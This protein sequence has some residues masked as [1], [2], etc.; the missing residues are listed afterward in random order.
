MTSQR[1]DPRADSTREQQRPDAAPGTAHPQ[2]SWPVVTAVCASTLLVVGLVAAI[3]LAVPGLARDPQMHPSGSQLLWVVDVYVVAFAALVVPAGA[4]GDRIGR[5]KALLAGLVLVALGTACSAI[6]PNVAVLLTVRGIAGIGAALVLPNCVG[7]LVQSVGAEQRQRALTV[8]ALCTG[9]GGI[10]GNIGGGA[11]IDA[12]SWRALFVAAAICA[13][14]CAVL[15]RIT[16]A[17]GAGHQRRY[18]G[19]GAALA[20][21]TVL[22]IIAVT[23]EGPASGWLH[24]IVIGLVVFALA[25]GA[26]WLGWELQRDES[27]ID[28]RLFRI[29]Q[30]ALGSAGILIAFF[31]CFGLFFLNASLLQFERGFSTFESGL[32]TLPCALPILI[33]G[34]LFTKITRRIHLRWTL[35]IGFVLIGGGLL[36]CAVFIRDS[37]AAYAV[38]LAVLGIG[39]AFVT[40][41]LTTTITNGLPAERAGLA[42]GLQAL[43]RELGSGL[44]VAVVGSVLTATFIRTL[45]ANGTHGETPSTPAAALQAGLAHGTVIDAYVGAC[46]AGLVVAAAVTLIVGALLVVV[47]LIHDRRRPTA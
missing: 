43:T 24:P 6:A 4:L 20:G 11:V 8:W 30:I 31:G 37:Y 15:I 33:G 25:A 5:R 14:I 21:L 34:P 38:G 40:P 7:V 45:H 28:P 2:R 23:I 26:A 36:L 32:A 22:G 46:Q 17:A 16:A 35:A 39:F 44:G 27:L 1:S 41:A 42:G 47:E 18:D 3:N 12:W 19:V 9:L 10:V 29:P 13:T